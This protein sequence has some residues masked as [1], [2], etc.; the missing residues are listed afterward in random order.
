MGHVL[1]YKIAAPPLNGV[2]DSALCNL[3]IYKKLLAKCDFYKR[4]FSNF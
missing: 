2:K 3:D 4:I 1:L